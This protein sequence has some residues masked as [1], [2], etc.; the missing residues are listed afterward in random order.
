LN[1]GQKFISREVPSIQ[2]RPFDAVNGAK[3]GFA[4]EYSRKIKSP[5]K[6]GMGERE[7]KA[8]RGE[9]RKR[10][11]EKTDD[12]T[13]IETYTS[14]KVVETCGSRKK[15]KIRIRGSMVQN[16]SVCQRSG[17]RNELGA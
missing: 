10:A 6:G 1:K 14:P 12:L 5:Q 2:P 16:L 4:L 15:K 9:G 11:R 3:N 8:F 13:G 17:W 7:K